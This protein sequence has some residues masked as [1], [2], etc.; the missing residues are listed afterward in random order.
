MDLVKNETI[1]GN[2]ESRLAEFN[3]EYED[4]RKKLEIE[5]Q[6]FNVSLQLFRSLETEYKTQ[7]EEVNKE[8]RTCKNLSI[9]L[10]NINK[11]FHS[12]NDKIL[13]VKTT[14]EGINSQIPKL[15]ANLS[16]LNENQV[17]VSQK[18][19][20]IDDKEAQE[21]SIA[22]LDENLKQLQLDIKPKRAK[23]KDL[24]GKS[25]TSRKINLR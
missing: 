1:Q 3:I 11:E 4:N 18:Q 9:E 8:E 19:E 22:D 7:L 20:L 14:I 10:S 13:V 15:Q 5:Q 24:K 21:K 12:N 16:R 6:E 25:K 17:A 23:K 2:T